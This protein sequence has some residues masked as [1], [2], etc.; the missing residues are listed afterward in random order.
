[1]IEVDEAA[2]AVTW[3]AK[4]I[5]RALATGLPKLIL[6]GGTDDELVICKGEK[7]I[8]ISDPDCERD[9]QL[10]ED[11]IYWRL[12]VM[13]GDKI[14]ELRWMRL[15][16]TDH[17][18]DTLAVVRPSVSATDLKAAGLDAAWQ[19]VQWQDA[20]ASQARRSR[21]RARA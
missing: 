13:H 9:Y 7:G 10:L 4:S 14:V 21:Q 5:L 8:L 12:P 2:P 15:C 18:S 19:A 16:D 20:K 3:P 11:G 6:F 17:F 1:M